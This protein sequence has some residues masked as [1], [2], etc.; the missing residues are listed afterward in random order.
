[1]L[2]MKKTADILAVF[3]LF[4]LLVVAFLARSPYSVPVPLRDSG[5]FLNIGS[6]I[7]HGKILYQQTWDNKQP[8]LYVF[9]A[10]G[11]W[12]SNGSVWGVWGLEL[13]LLLIVFYVSYRLVRPALTPLSAFVVIAIAF[14]AVFPFMGGNYSEEY[15]LVFQAG[16]LGVLFAM[17]LPNRRRF[18]RPLAAFVIGVLVGLVFCIK[19][20]YLDIP[21]TVLIFMGFLAW[22]EKDLRILRNILLVGLGFLL[23]NLPVFLY[24]QVNGALRDYVVNA[25]LFNRYYS[26]LTIL[27]RINSVLDK[28]KF[29][30]SHPFFFFV[31]S[32]WLGALILLAIKTRHVFVR[33]LDHPYTRRLTLIAALVCLALFIVAQSI[34]GYPQ[35]GFLQGL[36]LVT[37][38]IFGV[39]SLILYLRKSRSSYPELSY[40]E[41]LRSERSKLDWLHPGPATFLFLGL[42]DF[43]IVLLTIS[44]SGKP[45]T[46]YY[47]SLFP[48]IILLLAG[49]LAY[50][51]R[52]AEIP[53]KQLMLNTLLVAVLITGSYP[54]LNQVVANLKE[55]SGGDDRSR[56]AAYLK[57]VTTPQDTIL[58]WGWESVIYFLA[59]RESP[60][61]FALPFALYVDTPYLDEYSSILL[62]EVEARPPAYIAD[63][64]DP[65]MPLIDGRPADT[66]L[67][68]NQMTN[69][70][71][72]DF[73]AFVC[74]NYQE[75]RNFETINLYK[76]RVNQ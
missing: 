35:I 32:L 63:L 27:G 57:S 44:L 52:Y 71:M 9:N 34:G 36:T 14:L 70:G 5:I 2:R 1:M 16:I 75:D 4:V 54:P 39:V 47:I 60:T 19:Q 76:L 59:Q 22:V 10:V 41:M 38:I 7:L 25:F 21:V 43:P 74:A 64:R 66:C 13:A 17:Y 12:L 29:V 31:A 40:I 51:Y 3:L 56:A 45:W 30:S 28:I 42:I 11:L 37:G 20:T 55:P 72:V 62:K 8:L 73:L 48:G 23:V 18:S 58:V 50:L 65:G 46:H 15:S 33:A 24:F 67:S 68:G 69:Q 61:R 26:Y 49:S 53:S 6:E